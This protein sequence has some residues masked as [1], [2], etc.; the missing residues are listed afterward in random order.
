MEDF[1]RIVYEIVQ[2]HVP[3]LNQEALHQRASGNGKYLSVTI[4]IE[5]SSREQLDAIYYDLT[6]CEYI[7]MAL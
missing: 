5:A 2:K 7:L 1:D 4:T 6:S 3:E